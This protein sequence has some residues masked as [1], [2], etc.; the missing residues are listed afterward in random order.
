MSKVL[1]NQATSQQLVEALINKHQGDYTKKNVAS[2]HA[3][4]ANNSYDYKHD[5]ASKVLGELNALI[6]Q[7]GETDKDGNPTGDE[8]ISIQASKKFTLYQA[9]NAELA[10]LS[11]RKDAAF[12]AYK[13]TTGEA[14]K[15]Q[16]KGRVLTSK[17]YELS[18]IKALL[19]K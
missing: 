12:A 7:G 5:Q 13:A 1:L 17:N 8:V 18:E 16:P 11:E 4:A 3:Y 2:D 14:Y 10:E 15:P 9:I 19:A 6:E